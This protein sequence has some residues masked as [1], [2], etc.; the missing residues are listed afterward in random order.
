[1]H[2]HRD[3]V[4]IDL[5]VAILKELSII[6]SIQSL[7][8]DDFELHTKRV[9]LCWSEIGVSQHAFKKGTAWCDWWLNWCVR[10]VECCG[11][12]NSYYVQ[13]QTMAV[14]TVWELETQPRC[15]W[16]TWFCP[17]SSHSTN[18]SNVS[19]SH[20][21]W[22][23]CPEEIWQRILPSQKY[24]LSSLLEDTV[25][26]SSA[27]KTYPVWLIGDPPEHYLL[28]FLH[29]I[30]NASFSLDSCLCTSIVCNHSDPDV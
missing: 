12:L 16:Q 28:F 19:E 22:P 26:V 27:S 5:S 9:H 13:S 24:N 1:M 29:S 30:T 11:L 15:T 6:C 18:K 2:K 21:C 17:N 10:N 4:N 7:T 14:P 23:A 8:N 25:F 3:L 20:N